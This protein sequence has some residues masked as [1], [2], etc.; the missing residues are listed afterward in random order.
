[1]GNKLK[2][3]SF[4]YWNFAD[5]VRMEREVVQISLEEHEM[6]EAQKLLQGR[7]YD[8]L[9][10]LHITIKND[11]ILSKLSSLLKKK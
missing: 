6:E 4:N 11:E 10:S 1:M 8:Q 2:K 3:L 7:N 9:K 5:P